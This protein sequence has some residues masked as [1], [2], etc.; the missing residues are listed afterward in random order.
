M[1]MESGSIFA[2]PKG[3]TGSVDLDKELNDWGIRLGVS[4]EALDM[5]RKGRHSNIAVSVFPHVFCCQT[6]VL[7]ENEKIIAEIQKAMVMMGHGVAIDASETSWR[8]V[9]TNKNV[10]QTLE[11][12][13]RIAKQVGWAPIDVLLVC[14]KNMNPEQ[15]SQSTPV[16]G[17][18]DIPYI[19][20]HDTVVIRRFGLDD[21]RSSGVYWPT[22]GLE[23]QY[24]EASLWDQMFLVKWQNYWIHRLHVKDIRNIPYWANY[25]AFE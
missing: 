8:F 19:F 15:R 16:F 21:G 25:P 9:G 11:A 5:V 13:E 4:V 7:T 2:Y 20:A 18:R 23:L 1:S 17:I 14:R 10:S 24:A 6:L 12:Y 3:T 22:R